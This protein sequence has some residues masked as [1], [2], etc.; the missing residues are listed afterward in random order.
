MRLR[1]D[2]LSYRLTGFF[3][4]ERKVIIVKCSLQGVNKILLCLISLQFIFLISC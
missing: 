1:A 4:K 2:N 3:V